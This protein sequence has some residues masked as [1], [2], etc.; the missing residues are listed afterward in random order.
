M[1]PTP[2]QIDTWTGWVMNCGAPVFTII[3]VIAAGYVLRVIPAFPNKWIPAAG[4]AVGALV[5]PILNPHTVLTASF[6]TR[7]ITIGLL[8]GY[9]A[10]RFHDQFIS[11]WE[12]KLKMIYPGA[13]AVLTE[14]KPDGEK[15]SF[16]T[17]QTPPAPP[18]Q[19]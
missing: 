18:A 13:N 7:S 19:P 4:F 11:R 3:A 12:D 1:N 9:V 6:I 16:L 10:T 8:L 15:T 14:T 17:K 2:E 5:F